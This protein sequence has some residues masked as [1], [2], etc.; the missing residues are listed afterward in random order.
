M[1]AKKANDIQAKLSMSL[2]DLIASKKKAPTSGM[3]KIKG[4]RAPI[5]MKE[6]AKMV[7]V[8]W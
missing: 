5:S 3:P 8:F 6:N 2:D 4:G 1:S 7:R